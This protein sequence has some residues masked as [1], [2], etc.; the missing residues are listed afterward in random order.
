MS[1]LHIEIYSDLICPWCYIGRRRLESGIKQLKASEPPTILWRP[2]ELNP[3]MPKAGL[4]RK[5]YR[6]DKFGSW[7]ISQSMDREVA[8][9]GRTLGLDFNYGRI[10]VTPNTL[11]GHRLLWWVRDKGAQDKL[12]DALFRA[13]FTNGRDIGNDGVLAKVAAEVGLSSKDAFSFLQSDT[14]YNEVLAEEQAARRG[15]VNG[16]PF[17]VINGIPVFAGAQQPATFVET[18]QQILRAEASAV[19]L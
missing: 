14:G 18:F 8:E 1:S 19:R 10:L 11:A 17:F 12:A 7:E 9:T 4:D 13:Y 6:T 16:V 2:F 5:V 15:G 3:D